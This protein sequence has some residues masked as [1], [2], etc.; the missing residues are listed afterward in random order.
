MRHLLNYEIFEKKIYQEY[1]STFTHDSKEY[2]LNKMFR[3][4]KKRRVIEM[5]ISKLKWV[6][7]HTDIKK[8]RV[9]KA[10]I[11]IPILIGKLNKR[12]VVYDG[13][14]RLKAMIPSK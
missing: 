4:T 11:N 12:W 1:S 13:A 6:L 10:N 9:K 14:H 8:Y 2:N 3:L 5:P 7:K